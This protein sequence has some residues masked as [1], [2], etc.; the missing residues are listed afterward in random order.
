MLN[1][2]PHEINK[3]IPRDSPWITKPLK[4]MIRKKNRLYKA[5][6]KHGF[7]AND[8]IR[9]DN[10]RD[11]CQTAIEA[12]KNNYLVTQGNKLFDSR[13]KGKIYWK[14]LKN[15]I[16]K[17]KASKIPPMLVEN[18]FIL[19][20][21]EKAILFT[22]FFCEQCTPNATN[23]VLPTLVYKT[24]QRIDQI[25][26]STNHIVQLISKLNPNKATGSDGISPQMLLL[27]GDTAVSPLKIIFSSILIIYLPRQTVK[28]Q[29]SLYGFSL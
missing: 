10:F 4:T 19:D 13:S 6:K 5:Y 2:V 7:Q 12:A 27:C 15:V 23:N 22:K 16:N 21:K 11:E 8:K 28:L 25:P 24:N 29:Y 9:L 20:C 17:T 14:I 3:I 1:F 26:L 18:K